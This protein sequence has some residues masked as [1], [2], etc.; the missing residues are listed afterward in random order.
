MGIRT[1]AASAFVAMVAALGSGCQTQVNLTVRS[2]P[3]YA[4]VYQKDGVCFGTCP[5]HI[6][7]PVDAEQRTKGKG[8]YRGL[9]VRWPSGV[10]DSLDPVELTIN[11]TDREIIFRRPRDAPNAELDV[12]YAL[13]KERLDMERQR[14]GLMERNT[15]VSENINFWNSLNNYNNALRTSIQQGK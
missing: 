8:S 4:T 9:I 14:T 2:D 12:A 11:G 6:T 3:G 1:L 5:A 15:R 13:E 10:E 7:Y